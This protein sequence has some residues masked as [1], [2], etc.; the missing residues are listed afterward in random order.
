MNG[1]FMR[2][3]KALVFGSKTPTS[4]SQGM[5]SP[6]TDSLLTDS[7]TYCSTNQL[8][9]LLSVTPAYIVPVYQTVLPNVYNPWRWEDTTVD[10]D[11]GRR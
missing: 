5:F 2:R 8:P 7:Q 4:K 3:D 10:K 1:R 9:L 11:I 6:S